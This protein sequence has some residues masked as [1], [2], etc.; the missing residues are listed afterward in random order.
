MAYLIIKSTKDT[1]FNELCYELFMGEKI[2]LW[3]SL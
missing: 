2:R 1:D 3:L